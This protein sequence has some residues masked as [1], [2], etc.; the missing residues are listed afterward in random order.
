MNKRNLFPIIFALSF[1]FDSFSTESS[2]SVEP[3]SQNVYGGIG[4]V[5]MPSA[6]FSDDG[7]FLFGISSEQPYHR[8]YSKVQ[9]FPWMEAVVRYTEGTFRA[10][11]EG[12][13][14]TWKDKGIDFKFKLLEEDGK[15]PQ[16]AFGLTDFGGTGAFSSEYLVASKKIK[17]VDYTLGLG[18][19]RFGGLDHAKN[20][21]SI[22]DDNRSIRGGGS[23]LGGTINL[24]RFF[25]GKNMSFFGGLEYQSPLPNLTLKLEY[26]SSDY[27][28]V[29]NKETKFDEIG[30]IFKID[31]R[32]N[33]G[34]N[35]A[36]KVSERDT[37]DFSIG[38]IRGNTFYAGMAVHSNLNFLGDPKIILGAEKLRNTNLPASN[39]LDLDQN[40]QKFLTNRIIKEMARSGFVTHAVIYNENELA[41]EIS[42]GQYLNK[43]QYFD[44]ASRILANN[45]L[46][47]IDTIT[48]INIDQGIETM[49]STV[50]RSELRTAVLSGPLPEELISFNEY[51]EAREG[52]IIEKNEY[53]YPN[54]YWEIKPSMLGTIQHQEDFYFWQM[55]ALIST[56]Y[57]FKKG[58]YLS[59]DIGINIANNYERYTY[60]IPDG[61]LY[62][63]RQDRR[64]YLTEGESGLR[65]MA[66]DYLFDVNS[67]IKAK[68]TAGY[69]EWMYGGIGGEVLYMPEDRRWGLGFDA[70]F[71]KQRDFDQKFGFQDYQTLTGFLTYYQDIPFYDLRLKLSAG[72]FLAEDKGVHVD[73]SRRF[74][75]GA[76]VGGIIALTDCDAA[77]V[78]EGSFNKWIYFELP[79]DLF[80]LNS[81]TRKKTGYSWTPLTKDAGQKVEP[82][83]LYKL[84]MDTPDEINSVRQK[85]WSIKRIVSGFGTKAK[86]RT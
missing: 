64:L 6:R 72:R 19:G 78:G 35:Y 23:N 57:S 10:Y 52:R 40:R 2:Y 83:S 14:Q 31:S 13:H 5:Q 58:L 15:Y 61:E 9:I 86:A 11:N 29:L 8:L 74:K 60:H 82:G 62:H 1:S 47:N 43:T 66:I 68:I 21:F 39:Y 12:S 77:C 65:R 73:I 63:V 27:T 18:W 80:Y 46:E 55:Q 71:V 4:L 24:G 51:S 44:L 69:L 59:T 53:L 50:N 28:D 16:V 26:D 42:Q 38:Y 48:V 56:Q 75:T 17:N 25:S 49:R 54:F 45:A 79:M 81:S 7:Q 3:Y 85:Q 32:I 70:Y 36:F 84:V 20:V 30:D 67:N 37:I 41:A 22:F 76:R 34:L 33:Y